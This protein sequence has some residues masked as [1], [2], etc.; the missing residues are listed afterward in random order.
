[1]T[2]AFT[3]GGTGGHF[4]P[5]IAIAEAVRAIA[6]E[7]RLVTPRLYYLA[8][9]PFDEQALLGNGIIY[10]KAPAGKWRRYR[11][12]KNVTDAFMT[13][14]GYLKCLWLLF[15]TY[16]DVVVSKGGYAS[17]PTVLAAATLR[18]PI[19][20]HESD[21]K[22][23]RANLLAAR[24][25]TRIAVS[26]DESVAYFPQKM[27]SK[28]ARTGIPLRQELKDLIP[29]AARAELGLDASV[30]TILVLGGSS[31]A[32][33]INET[34]LSTLSELVSFANVIH[35]TGKANIEAVE[36]TAKVVLG[37]DPHANRYHPTAYLSA[38]AMR[39]A[40]SAADLI[41]SRAGATAIAEI[42]LW[43]KPAILIPIPEDVSHDQR[44]NAYA[45]A[46]TGAAVVLEEANMT[47]HLLASEA[48]RI[49]SDK[50]LAASMGEKGA[51]FSDNDAASVLG[52]EV[53]RIALSHEYQGPI[54]A[55]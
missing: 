33:R 42:S 53:L 37:K 52:E 1:M 49:L 38:P 27:R 43:R 45:Y 3:A 23:G 48:K 13:F 19:I 40:A 50:A 12:W 41:V 17:V 24:F 6:A 22:P 29:D 8:P 35:Q 44:T 7:R 55:A 39:E 2:I 16:P 9:T 18:I 14:A 47:P 15:Q 11:S 10:L 5:L 36:G 21:A 30:P 25:A 34:L 4:Y 54:P 46:K 28:I 32:V 20:I 31:G 26:F 51:A